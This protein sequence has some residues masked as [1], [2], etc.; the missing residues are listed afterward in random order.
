MNT[1]PTTQEVLIKTAIIMG[2]IFGLMIWAIIATI[3][4]TK[5]IRSDWDKKINLEVKRLKRN[6][7]DSKISLVG[8]V[9]K[10]NR[11]VIALNSYREMYL[12]LKGLN[13]G[14]Y[15]E[16]VNNHEQKE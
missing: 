13:T 2:P 9:F 8:S 1:I 4:D 5:K 16:R 11:L 12:Y 7:R 15:A 14:A 3:K 6:F 10:F